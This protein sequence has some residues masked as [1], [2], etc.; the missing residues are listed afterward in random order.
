MRGLETYSDMCNDSIYQGNEAGLFSFANYFM[1]TDCH[2][3][4]LQV[5]Y[6]RRPMRGISHFYLDNASKGKKMK[7]GR[8]H[9]ALVLS[10][11]LKFL[12]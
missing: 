8:S 12:R 9:G 5:Y 1:I 6:K 7:I 10:L 4:I 3:S 11:I 2:F